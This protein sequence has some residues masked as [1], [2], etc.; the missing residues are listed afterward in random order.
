M[1]PPHRTCYECE[2][3]LL[4]LLST[5]SPSAKSSSSE[6]GREVE[7]KGECEGGREGNGEGEGGERGSVREGEREMG[8][9]RGERGGEIGTCNERCRSE[10]ERSKQGQTNSKATQHTQGSRVTFPKKNELPRVGLQPPTLYTLDMYTN[11][12]FIHVNERLHV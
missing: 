5:P 2:S 11:Y 4:V 9:V 8:R 3:P 7:G 10:E 12:T 1:F 6:R